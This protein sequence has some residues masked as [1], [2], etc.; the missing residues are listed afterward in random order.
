MQR[1]VGFLKN[2]DLYPK[3]NGKLLKSIM[4]EGTDIRLA[5]LSNRSGGM[6]KIS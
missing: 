4:K 1:L 6:W 3:S 5:F 2:F